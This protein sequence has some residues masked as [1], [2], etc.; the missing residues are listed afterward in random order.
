M[1]LELLPS[2]AVIFLLGLSMG[3]VSEK[4]GLPPLVGMMG[5]GM[6]LGDS[7]FGLLGEEI[8]GISP[9]LRQMALIL[10]LLKAGL[11]LQWDRLKT[12]GRPAFL[13]S[14]L[15]ATCEILA[16]TFFA[17]L[18]F[19]VSTVEAALMG[20]VLAAVSPAVV[21]PRMVSYMER[22]L[23][24]KSK[25]PETILAGASLDDVLVMVLFSAM[26][27]LAQQGSF[28]M[29]TLME[30]PLSIVLGILCG[31]ACG[32]V[33]STT[34]FQTL[35]KEHQI[36]T[37]FALSCSFYGLEH[38]LPLSPLLAVMALGLT[39]HLPDKT[40]LANGVTSLWK[41]A[42]ILLFV[43]VGSQVN[44]QASGEFGLMAVVVLCFGLMCRSV[45]VAFATSGG[46]LSQK[47][48]LFAVISYL[49]KA[50]VQAGIGA[51]PLSVGLACGELILTVA[52]LAILI[53]APLGAFLIDRF[54]EK[55]LEE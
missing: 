9:E 16:C 39:L 12:V 43:L 47:Q 38:Y 28:A 6:L 2:L 24:Q 32:K 35:A 44:I 40:P 4:L 33:L 10:I 31:G 21:V 22:G 41:G 55:L 26:L 18:V 23:G 37:L 45:G 30:I 36:V 29:S 54:G 7:G 53:T 1:T 34:F 11:T 14:F 20:C 51:I 49:P 5:A 52:V 17:P 25:L 46:K 50:T 15:P 3:K 8:K 48:R 27:S 19:P 13:L 42:E